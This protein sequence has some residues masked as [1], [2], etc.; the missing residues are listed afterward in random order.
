MTLRLNP[1]LATQLKDL[2][3][4]NSPQSLASL[5][6]QYTACTQCPLAIQGRTQVVFGVGPENAQLF[7]IGEA[8]GKDEDEQGTPFI[9]RSGRLLRTILTEIG[10]DPAHVYISNTTKCR[11]PLNRPPTAEERNTCSSLIL[12]K[13]IAYLK[14]RAICTLGA[15]ATTL[16]FPSSP[17]ISQLRGQITQTEYFAIMPTYHPSYLLRNRQA[18]NTVKNDIMRL[19]AFLA[20]NP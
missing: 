14:P 3:A 18:I 17:P 19:K 11:P 12:L 1:A 9:G 20:A 8:P 5:K 6:K 7:F 4:Q 10:C 15:T 13:E 2:Y 16:F